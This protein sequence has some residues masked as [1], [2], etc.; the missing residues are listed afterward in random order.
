M[1][2]TKFDIAK[3]EGD[4]YNIESPEI[5]VDS[6]INIIIDNISSV[7]VKIN[8][9]D[10]S[11]PP[12]VEK[13][14][15]HNLLKSKRRIVL[16]YKSYSSHIEA[17]Y[18]I[19]DKSIVNGK[20]NAMFLLNEMYCLSLEKYGIDA[21]KPDIN[22]IRQHADDIV[23]DVIN[24]LKKFVYKSANVTKFKEQIEIGVSVVV[25]HAFVECFILENP[26]ATY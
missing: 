4:F 18:Y 22:Q 19:A 7:D 25:A 2:G 5:N 23:G 13:K 6:I 12:A 26:N 24:Q 14:I 17:A 8:I 20:Q 1:C 3:I 9:M 10:R 21:F 11:F 16:H 15:N